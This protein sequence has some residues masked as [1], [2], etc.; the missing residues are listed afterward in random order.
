MDFVFFI[1]HPRPPNDEVKHGKNKTTDTNYHV[2]K[3]E[4]LI[5]IPFS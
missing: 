3:E 4:N 5:L 2:Q 1:F